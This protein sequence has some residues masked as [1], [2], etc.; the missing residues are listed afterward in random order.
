MSDNVGRKIQTVGSPWLGNSGAGIAANL[1]AVF[2]V[3]CGM[4]FDL[5]IVSKR[6][7]LTLR[8]VHLCG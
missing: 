3:G 2:G 1:V 7:E 5:T 8:M 6:P 4:N